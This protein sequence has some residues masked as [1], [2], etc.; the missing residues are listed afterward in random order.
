MYPDLTQKGTPGNT[1]FCSVQQDPTQPWGGQLT[2]KDANG[3]PEPSNINFP[4]VQQM[5]TN[6]LMSPLNQIDNAWA[7]NVLYE[8][9]AGQDV[10]AVP[11]NTT[12]PN[13]VPALSP[14]VTGFGPFNPATNPPLGPPNTRLDNRIEVPVNGLVAQLENNGATY[15]WNTAFS[16]YRAS[17]PYGLCS[18]DRWITNLTDFI[19]NTTATKG[20]GAGFHPNE[21]G[22]QQY[23][24][25]LTTTLL[26]Q[27]P[28]VVPA[29]TTV[30]PLGASVTSKIR[31]KLLSPA[32]I[33]PGQR[34]RLQV[35][36]STTGPKSGRI[37]VRAVN[38]KAVL[39][40]TSVSVSKSGTRTV[41]LPRKWSRLGGKKQGKVR[42][43]VQFLGNISVRP[44]NTAKVTQLI[45]RPQK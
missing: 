42:V 16:M 18:P 35:K 29:F 26:G 10:V 8:G 45:G 28:A 33:R 17:H 14:V 41:T 39:R 25:M 37:G 6:P 40:S 36:V 9:K 27:V 44:S 4:T 30:Q 21:Q 2:L 20:T 24:S 34:M 11:Q 19:V 32:T 13:N 31:V 7:Y 15:G 43:A 1:Q 38:T 3:L 12:F 23:A 5:L 22:Q